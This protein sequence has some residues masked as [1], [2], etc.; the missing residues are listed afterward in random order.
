[1]DGSGGVDLG[2]VLRAGTIAQVNAAGAIHSG[3]YLVW[4]VRHH[5]STEKHEMKFVLV[6][7]AVNAPGA[8]VG[9][10]LGL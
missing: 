9:G 6:R 4:S 8:S 5:I 1:M 7:N 2:S 10:G 3:P